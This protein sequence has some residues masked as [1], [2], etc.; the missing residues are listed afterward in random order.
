MAWF[1]PFEVPPCPGV[2]LLCFGTADI[3]HAPADVRNHAGYAISTVVVVGDTHHLAHLNRI[4]PI[5]AEVV[6]GL[7]AIGATVYL[8]TL[9]IGVMMLLFAFPVF[10]FALRYYPRQD[11]SLTAVRRLLSTLVFSGG[12]C[13][14]D[15]ELI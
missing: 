7:V 15:T 12:V 8:P 4:L 11:C 1:D 6:S 5:V 10:S 9:A 13:S 3:H 2:S 14:F